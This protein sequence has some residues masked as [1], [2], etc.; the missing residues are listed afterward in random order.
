MRHY[1]CRSRTVIL[2]DVVVRYA[3]D[4]RDCAG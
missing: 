1:L 4:L 3:C 2:H